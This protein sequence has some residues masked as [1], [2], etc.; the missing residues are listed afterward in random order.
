[1][2]VVGVLPCWLFE[3]LCSHKAARIPLPQ[4]GNIQT[5]SVGREGRA[6]CLL[7]KAGRRARERGGGVVGIGEVGGPRPGGN[8]MAGP[9]IATDDSGGCDMHLCV[10]RVGQ[11]RK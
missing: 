1:M 2:A 7:E 3:H 5:S 11:C 9:S 6:C 10:F 8:P 4:E